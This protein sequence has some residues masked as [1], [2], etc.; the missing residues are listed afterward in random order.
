MMTKAFCDGTIFTGEAFVE[1]HALLIADGKIA[2]IVSNRKVPVDAEKISYGDKIFVPGFIDT[3]INGG[4]G[5]LL[6]N[7]PTAEACLAIAKVHHKRGTTR[8][9]PTCIS[10]RPE[11][12][13]KALAAVREARQKDKSILGIHIEGPHLSQVRR[14]IHK[15]DCLRAMTEN[16]LRLYKPETDEIMLI[17]VAPETVPPEQIKKLRAQGVIVSIGHTQ[18]T[19]DQVRAALAAGATGFTHLFNGMGKDPKESGSVAVALSDRD[20]WCGIIADGFHVTGEQFALALKSKP[21]GKL[22]LVSDAV[23]PAASDNPQSFEFYGETIRFEGGRCVNA[24]GKLAGSAITL[25]DAVKNC[26]D[27]FAVD[28]AEA[29]R[30]ASMYPAAFLGLDHHFGKLLPGYTADVVV[31]DTGFNVKSVIG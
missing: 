25:A 2:D 30:M 4:G 15:A 23:S 29:L 18:A 26:I 9:L 13:H 21:Q 11:V 7:T 16:D 3:Q 28:S 10:D 6:N 27:K 5:V 17:T 8:L 22:F 31:M 20:S 14:G 24:E 19:A 1:S 12:T